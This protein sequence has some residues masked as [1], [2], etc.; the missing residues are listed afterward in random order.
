MPKPFRLGAELGV[1]ET[2]E[3][4][5]PIEA[6]M[7]WHDKYNIEAGIECGCDADSLSAV[8]DEAA[9][10]ILQALSD[11]RNETVEDGVMM[12]DHRTNKYIKGG[13]ANFN[14]RKQLRKL[15]E[16]IDWP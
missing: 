8:A 6:L 2:A 13:P 10:L 5:C 1:G 9:P 15:H 11:S 14:V 3:G 4:G 16:M 12:Y 7:S